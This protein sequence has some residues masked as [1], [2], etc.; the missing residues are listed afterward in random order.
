MRELE[1]GGWGG[2]GRG[3]ADDAVIA[4]CAVFSR[5]KNF[6]EALGYCGR[7]KSVQ[8]AQ[9]LHREKRRISRFCARAEIDLAA[10]HK[11]VLCAVVWGGGVY[12]AIGFRN[13]S[14]RDTQRVRRHPATRAQQIGFIL[15]RA[16]DF[17]RAIRR[18]I[19]HSRL[20]GGLQPRFAP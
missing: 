1:V 19:T 10:R 18:S 2:E 6:S 9:I 4:P 3:G 20:G 5:P 16:T 15:V 13:V 11:Y 17:V 12:C 7:R 14:G 8:Q